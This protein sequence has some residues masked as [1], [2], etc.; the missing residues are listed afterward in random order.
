MNGYLSPV[1][2]PT[3]SDLVFD[4]LADDR[5]PAIRD[6]LARSGRDP[7]DRDAFLIPRETV[8][9]IRELR[10]E[11]GVGEGMDQLVALVHH[12]YL[13]WAG[14]R[15]VLPI[16]RAALDA[17]MRAPAAPVGEELPAW[18]A[19]FPERRVWAQ[20]L[21]SPSHEPL[22][23][24]F[25]HHALNG[26]LR[27]LAVLG[28]HADRDGFTVAESEGPRPGRLH[29]PDDAAPFSSVLQGGAAAGL[30]SVVGAPELLELGWRSQSLAHLAASATHTA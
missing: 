12:A 29:R 16:D 2:R 24:V 23:G 7:R 25:V 18:Y 27:V 8:T 9:L 26:D 19:Q 3:P 20:V 5:F 4:P 28:L 17:M 13:F 6:A 15:R 21:D 14:E 1:P 22:D 11:G 30:Y 10:P